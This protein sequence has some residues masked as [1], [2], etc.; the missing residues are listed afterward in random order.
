ML[1][2]RLLRAGLTA[3]IARTAALIQLAVELPAAVIARCLG[4]DIS[5]AVAW[6]RAAAG[7]WHARMRP[8]QPD[9]QMVHRCRSTS[10][11][12]SVGRSAV[13]PPWRK[14]AVMRRPNC[15]QPTRRGL[16]S[17]RRVFHPVGRHFGLARLRL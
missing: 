3:R 2:K 15:A 4:I 6:L 17:R 8:A 14:R 5:S 13:A 11:G 16:A 1:R 10:R 12:N 7:Y 9:S